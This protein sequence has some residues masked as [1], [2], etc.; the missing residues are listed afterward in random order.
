MKRNQLLLQT[1][2]KFYKN[3]KETKT[4]KDY[5]QSNNQ[6]NPCIPIEEQNYN[7]KLKDDQI[8]INYDTAQNSVLNYK[9]VFFTE[10]EINNRNKT[11]SNQSNQKDI[12]KKIVKDFLKQRIYNLP[13]N[14]KLQPCDINHEYMTNLT[15]LRKQGL[16][17]VQNQFLKKKINYYK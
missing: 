1:K 3:T 14:L 6:S 16:N 4:A 9:K 10:E 15:N 2:N 7:I 17:E 12:N 5:L 11:I 13:E 8:N